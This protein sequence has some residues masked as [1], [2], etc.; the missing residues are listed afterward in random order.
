MCDKKEKENKE[1]HENEKKEKKKRSTSF[2]QL[3]AK[4]WG[5]K[6]KDVKRTIDCFFSVAA[7]QLKKSGSVNIAGMLTLKLKFRPA[8]ARRGLNP[9]TKEP[10]NAQP[11]SQTVKAIPLKGLRRMTDTL[12]FA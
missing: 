5:K 1:K 4:R 8:T 12:I 9:F 2:V 6:P 7:E 11:A 10:Y 3:V